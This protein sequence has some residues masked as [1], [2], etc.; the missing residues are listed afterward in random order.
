M[1]GE[2]QATLITCA[3]VL[4][5]RFWSFIEHRRTGQAVKGNEERLQTIE[6]RLNGELEETIKRIIR[7][8][9]E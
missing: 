6:T 5:M 2:A 7:E 8:K 3:F 1:T 9:M 4:V